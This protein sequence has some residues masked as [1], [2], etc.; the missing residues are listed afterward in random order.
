MF[1]GDRSNVCGLLLVKKLIQLDPDDCIPIRT[2]QGAFQVPP[3]CLTTTPL[4]EQLNQFQTGRSEVPFHKKT[5]FFCFFLLDFFS[6]IVFVFVFIGH[7][8]IV[9]EEGEHDTDVSLLLQPAIMACPV[10]CAYFILSHIHTYT[11]H[12]LLR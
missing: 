5:V 4:Y 7:V 10:I 6:A 3:S 1:E 8:S 12:C 9:Y 2:I 11:Q